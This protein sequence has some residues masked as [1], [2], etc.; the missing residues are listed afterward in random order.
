MPSIRSLNGLGGNR[1]CPDATDL[2]H[3]AA[4]KMTES[5]R[6]SRLVLLAALVLCLSIGCN[7][8][9]LSRPEYKYD[10]ERT[11]EELRRLEQMTELEEVLGRDIEKLSKMLKKRESVKSLRE[12]QDLLVQCRDEY[13]KGLKG[14]SGVPLGGIGAGT[15]ELRPDGGLH[16]WRIAGNWDVAKEPEFCYFAVRTHSPRRG[17]STRVLQNSD[18]AGRMKTQDIGYDGRFPFVFLDYGSGR[19]PVSTRCVVFSP[20]IPHNAE[21]SCLPLACFKF[22]LENTSAED[23][24]VSI[25]FAAG[26]SDLMEGGAVD[27]D[28]TED[29]W[30]VSYGS[31][32]DAV[33]LSTT[34]QNS[35]HAAGWPGGFLPPEFARTGRLGD[36][37][38]NEDNGRIALCTE[39]DLKPHES[40]DALFLL[41]WFF[42]DFRQRPTRSYQMEV[43]FKELGTTQEA[44]ARKY[45][46]RRYNHFGSAKGVIRYFVQNRS[47]LEDATR[48]WHELIQKSTLDDKLKHFLPNSLYP[49][50]KTSFWTEN[51]L[52]NILE[53][54]NAA[55]NL[56]CVHVRYY[57]SIPLAL[58]F[59]EL[60]KQVLRRLAQHRGPFGG[61]K[62][63]QIPEQFY[64]FCF[65]IPFGR[66]LLQNNLVFVLMVYRDYV[67]TGDMEFLREMWPAVEE[68]MALAASADTDADDLPDETGILQ[69]YD[70]YDMGDSSA[71]ISGIWLASLRAAEEIALAMNKPEAAKNFHDSFVESRQSMED[72]LWAGEYYAFTEGERGKVCFADMLNGQ[73]YAD[74][75]GLGDLLD[76]DRVRSSLASVFKYNYPATPY[77]IV[78]GFLPGSGIDFP[79]QAGYFQAQSGSVWTGA[80][81]AVASLGLYRGFYDEPM[82][83][84]GEV[85]DNYSTRLGNLWNLRE[86]N[87]PESGLPMAWP[88]YYRAMSLWSVLLGVEGFRYNAPE[89]RLTIRPPEK[90]T[91]LKAPLI[92]P[93]AVAEVELDG[94]DGETR[95]SITTHSG[96]L[97]VEQVRMPGEIPDGTPEHSVRLRGTAVDSQLSHDGDGHVVT[98]SRAQQIRPKET[99]EI[100]IEE[101]QAGVLNDGQTAQNARS[102]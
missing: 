76:R 93:G 25:M 5:P 28:R 20:L 52:F 59:P 37:A 38:G 49:L 102:R 26:M 101:G 77:G 91:H 72:L 60:D 58:M 19:Q 40:K 16:D 13:L 57:G 90:A 99:L 27:F 14:E 100:T 55:P 1:I 12:M 88:Y 67:W 23:V 53:S 39:L 11:S 17:P 95:L 87:D 33:A 94:E 84:V 66:A 62:K 15:V 96:A 86:A 70:D 29:I 47:R 85:Y 51:G 3:A 46:G 2:M 43:K 79:E 97:R 32:R 71:Y 44:E 98:L 64:G 41:S 68:A 81:F 8:R 74:M 22:T 65:E 61:E 78:N 18:W 4:G 50:F 80:T 24:H 82:R 10:R 48:Q 42:P 54:T 7:R 69:S 36:D 73:W 56:D 92:V 83:A 30:T 75:L 9:D 35:S 89:A 45:F 34:L 31:G 21:D 63:G 6:R